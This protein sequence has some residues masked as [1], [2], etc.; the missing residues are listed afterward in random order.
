MSI[1]RIN[2]YTNK[3]THIFYEQFVTMFI[4]LL[5]KETKELFDYTLHY[6]DF[7]VCNTSSRVYVNWEFKTKSLPVTS[8]RI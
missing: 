8:Y 1:H 3:F 7:F 2:V 5:S 6:D 4:N